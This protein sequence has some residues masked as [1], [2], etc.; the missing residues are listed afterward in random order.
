MSHAQAHFQA[1]SPVVHYLQH[2][3]D[4]GTGQVVGLAGCWKLSHGSA[5]TLLAGQAGKLR[6]AH[7]RVWITFDDAGQDSVVRAGDHFL[8]AGESIALAAGRS[9]VMESF[10]SG[11]ATAAYFTWEP[12]PQTS[13]AMQ[14]LRDLLV[15][16][17]L[18]G[19]AAARLVR[20]VAGGLM[21]GARA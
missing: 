18:V 12:V 14:L 4:A 15:A 9:L 2:A 1:V 10:V 3:A 8:E 20:G 7:G 16:V 19:S 13:G 17:G 6:I 5:L 11:Q 21:G